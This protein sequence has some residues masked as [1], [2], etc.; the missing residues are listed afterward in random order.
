V[1]ASSQQTLSWQKPEPHWLAAEQAVPFAF[2]PDAHEP[3]PS[4]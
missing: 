1:H 4:Q 2:R 3:V